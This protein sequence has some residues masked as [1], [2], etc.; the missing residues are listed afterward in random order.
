METRREERINKLVQALKREDKLHLK[1][2]AVLLGVSEMTIRRDLSA[3]PGQ[4]VLLGGY[5]VNDPKISTVTHY[6]VSDQKAKHVK[7]KGMAGRIAAQLIEADDTVFFDCGTTTPLI[8]D[9]IEQDLSFTGVCY[10]LNTFLALQD[11]PNCKVILCGGEFH[12]AN[13]IFTPLTQYSVLDNICPDKAFISAAGVDLRHGATCFNFDELT[14]KHR[15]LALSQRAILVAD[16]SKF[17]NIKPA[18]IGALT[19]F[20]TLITDRSPQQKFHD[21]CQQNTITLLYPQE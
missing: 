17:D 14:M 12:P 18:C 21:Y 20:D 2:A 15:A 19:L 16:G 3:E 8:I 7:E 9:A 6:F 10:S 4:V 5:V 1:D 13:C 11:L